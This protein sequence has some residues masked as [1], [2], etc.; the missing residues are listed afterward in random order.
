MLVL[1]HCG[2]AS[3]SRTVVEHCKVPKKKINDHDRKIKNMRKRHTWFIRNDP[4]INAKVLDGSTRVEAW[5]NILK[6]V[7]ATHL[8]YPGPPIR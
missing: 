2:L 8:V 4:S 6:Q 5:R 3:A 1:R 7:Q